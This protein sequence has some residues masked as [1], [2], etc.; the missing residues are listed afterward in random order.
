MSKIRAAAL[1]ALL[2]TALLGGTVAAAPAEAAGVSSKVI[3][4]C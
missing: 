4:C 1:S 2:A 3:R